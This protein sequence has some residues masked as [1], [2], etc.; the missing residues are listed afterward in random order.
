MSELRRNALVGALLAFGSM[1]ASCKDST[2]TADAGPP[3]ASSSVSARPSAS[4]PPPPLPTIISTG[5]AGHPHGCV[6]LGLK[7]STT[8]RDGG[9]IADAMKVEGRTLEVAAGGKITV[10]SVASGKEIAFVGPASAIACRGGDEDEHWLLGGAAEVTMSASGGETWLVVP[11]FAVL[12]FAGAAVRAEVGAQLSVTVPSGVAFVLPIGKL[13]PDAGAPDEGGFVR[14]QTGQTLAI[15]KAASVPKAAV[16]DCVQAANDARAL[17]GA[18]V[19][20]DAAIGELAGKHVAAR[21]R[22]RALC[23][24][25]LASPGLDPK[26]RARAEAADNTWRV[27]LTP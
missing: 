4:S 27:V 10:K 2:P 12:R 21:K 19:V 15:A 9:A 25:A 5:D 3:V 8:E 14:V 16:A 11:G 26:E 17:A 22:A 1:I 7:G 6:A 20:P 18:L 24:V 13:A 23:T